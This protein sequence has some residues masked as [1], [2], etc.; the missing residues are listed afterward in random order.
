M[1]ARTTTWWDLCRCSDSTEENGKAGTHQVP[2][3]DDDDGDVDVSL[4][5]VVICW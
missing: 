2:G 5:L 3:D 1:L 4:P